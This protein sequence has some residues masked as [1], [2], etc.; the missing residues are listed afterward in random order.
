MAQLSRTKKYQELRDQL[1]EETTAAQSKPSRLSRMQANNLSHAS[2]P[3][4]PHQEVKP[5]PVVT[6]DLTK[7]PVMDDLLDEV[8]QYNIENGHRFTD[9]TQ[10]NILKQLDGNETR[11]RNA[12]FIPMEDDTDE[13]GSTMQMP[14]QKAEE[15][16]GVA[17]YM[18]NQKLTRINPVGLKEQKKEEQ[19]FEES[20][21][22]ESDPMPKPERI[23]LGNT[24]IRADDPIEESDKLSFFETQSVDDF[25]RTLENEPIRPSKKQPKKV[26]KIKKSKVKEKT[27]A[28][29]EDLPSAKMRMKAGD[30]DNAPA[31]KKAKK[32]GTILNVVL[33]ILILLLLASI[34]VTIYF[35]MNIGS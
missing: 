6:Q 18:P 34:A 22:Q 23:V 27:N 12:H 30:I 15:V 1:E 8:K 4:H 9:D 29:D 21:P 28:Q 31:Q 35:L 7:S 10:I 16:N 17:T 33:V 19:D 24:D 20:I 11:R 2:Q 32:T 14:K 13:L 25:D 5:K 3:L 26:K